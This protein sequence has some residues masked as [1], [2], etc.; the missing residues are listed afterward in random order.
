M[1]FMHDQLADGRSYRLFNAVDDCNREGLGI[2]VDFSL[3]AERVVRAL[4]QIIEWR[5]MAGLHR[6]EINK[7]ENDTFHGSVQKARSSFAS[8]ISKLLRITSPPKYYLT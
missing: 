2:E 8:T 3:P 4:D 5:G 1:D 6:R 7:I